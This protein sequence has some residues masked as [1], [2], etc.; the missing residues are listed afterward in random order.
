MRV[1]AFKRDIPVKF[2]FSRVG[3]EPSSGEDSVE[4]QQPPLVRT[5]QEHSMA[6]EGV[7]ATA[8]SQ[9]ERGTSGHSEHS[10]M[11]LIGGGDRAVDKRS[12]EVMLENQ[13]DEFV[14]PTHSLSWMH[15]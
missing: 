11:R 7:S 3:S 4:G 8:V 2:E 6:R 10:T 9:G 5:P 12:R 13:N 15:D 14:P 1:F